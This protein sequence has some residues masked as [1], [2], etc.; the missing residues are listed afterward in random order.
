MKKELKAAKKATKKAEAAKRDVEE[1]RA[2]CATPLDT[3]GASW[4]KCS[5]NLLRP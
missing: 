3:V 2:L 1:V 4:V 5:C